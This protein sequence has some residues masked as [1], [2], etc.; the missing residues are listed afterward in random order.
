MSKKYTF[1]RE[2][3]E[4][5]IQVDYE[6]MMTQQAGFIELP[7]GVSARRVHELAVRK[8]AENEVKTGTVVHAS[9]ALG[10]PIEQIGDFEKDR[11]KH[12]FNGVEFRP[13]PSEPTFVRPHFTSKGQWEKYVKHRGMIDKNSVNGSGA[14]MSPEIFEKSKEIVLRQHNKN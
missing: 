3:D 4:K 10:F 9:D 13:D 1:Q 7:D 11:V 8:K 6:T 12:G 5:L 14:V 2:D